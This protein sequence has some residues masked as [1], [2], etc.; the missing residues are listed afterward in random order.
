MD[1]LTSEQLRDLTRIMDARYQSEMDE[2]RAI[3][4]RSRDA[5]GQALRDGRPADELDAAL[6]EIFLATESALVRQN[7]Q[8]MRDIIA[9]RTRLAAGTYGTCIECGANIGYRRL[10]AYPTAKRCIDCQRDHEHLRERQG[11]RRMS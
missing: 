1:R 6:A 3:S 10:L 8:D 4:E 9:A 11:G 2:L 7:A 5:R